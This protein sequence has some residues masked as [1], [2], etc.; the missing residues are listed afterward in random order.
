MSKRLNENLMPV[1][2]MG[3]IFMVPLLI[4]IPC[5]NAEEVHIICNKDVP[6]DELSRD[7]V[8]KIFLG[9]TTEWNSQLGA[10]FILRIKNSPLH[11]QFLKKYIRKSAAQYSMYWKKRLFMG[12]GAAPKS[13]K[14]EAD[15]IEY[16]ANTKG[17]IGY[18]SQASNPAVKIISV[19]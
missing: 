7:E 4:G 1:I 19:Q 11:K 12:A 9:L 16:V 17:A 5:V 14:S 15:L 8:K 18:A 6:V 13:L 10:K 2:L 3:I